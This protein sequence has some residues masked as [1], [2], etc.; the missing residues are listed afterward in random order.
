M[1][2]STRR[3]KEFSH[4]IVANFSDPRTGRSTL[5]SQGPLDIPWGPTCQ[6]MLVCCCEFL[7]QYIYFS[8]TLSPLSWFQMD[9]R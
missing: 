2:F 3:T 9:S 8:W 7:R 6:T 4:L 1:L 5:T